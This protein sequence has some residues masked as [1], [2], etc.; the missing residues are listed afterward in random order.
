MVVGGHSYLLA[1]RVPKDDDGAASEGGRAGCQ[2]HTQD[3]QDQRVGLSIPACPPV[4]LPELG[5]WVAWRG[6]ERQRDLGPTAGQAREPF[7]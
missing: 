7:H 3:P 6:K 2:K 1:E 5:I 4:V